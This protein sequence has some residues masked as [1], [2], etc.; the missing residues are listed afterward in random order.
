[1]TETTR[2]GLV[3]VGMMGRPMAQRILSAGFPLTI[4]DVRTEPQHEFAALGANVAKSPRDVAANCD[5]V[6]TSLPALAACEQVYLGE[7]GL[8]EGAKKG[9]VLVETSTVSPKTVKRFAEAAAPRGVGVIDGALLSRTRFHP[10]LTQLN[11][12]E[13]VAKGQVTVLVGGDPK[14]VAKARPVLAA[15]GDPILEFGAVGSGVMIKVLNAAMTHAYYAVAS[16]VMAVASKAGIDIR[17][18]EEVFRHTSASSGAMNNNMPH[19]LQTGKGKLMS[20]ESVLKDSEA[21]L[22]VARDM[23][24]PVMMQNVNHAYYEM[25]LHRGDA[26]HMPWDGELMKLWESF[27]GQP[28]RFAPQ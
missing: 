12:Y 1:M 4:F 10:G 14:H 15:F 5:V 3:G 25:A 23:N 18:L 26:R 2:V 19:Y 21:M 22:E 6:L 28:I 24:V 13:I 17:K 27:I 20:L 11:S 9:T 7:S 8:L 16:E